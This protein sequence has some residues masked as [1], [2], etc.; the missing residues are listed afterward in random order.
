M[1]YMC[2]MKGCKEHDGTG[3]KLT[4][5]DPPSSSPHYWEHPLHK[6]CKEYGFKYGTDWCKEHFSLERKEGE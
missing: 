1:G 3:C 4:Y 6:A 5:W 2:P